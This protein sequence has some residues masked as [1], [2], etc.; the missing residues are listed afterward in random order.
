MSIR[1]SMY[2]HTFSHG[3]KYTVT[4]RHSFLK[5]GSQKNKYIKIGTVKNIIYCNYTPIYQINKIRT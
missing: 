1:I 4:W 3:F 5:R 2:I